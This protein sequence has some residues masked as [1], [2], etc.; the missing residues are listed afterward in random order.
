MS[1]MRF[2]QNMTLEP[3]F[4]R[5]GQRML[6]IYVGHRILPGRRPGEIDCLNSSEAGSQKFI[7]L[8]DRSADFLD[9]IAAT[10]P[11]RGAWRVD[12]EELRQTPVVD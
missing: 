5:R 6:P 12:A 9:L 3:S 1:V 7:C 8:S 4:G 10:N 2:L 11:H